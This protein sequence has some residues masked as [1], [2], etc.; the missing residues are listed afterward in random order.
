M[1]DSCLGAPQAHQ[2][3]GN[4]QL[5]AT[6]WAQGLAGKQ[7]GLIRWQ[8]YKASGNRYSCICCYLLASS[9]LDEKHEITMVFMSPL[10]LSRN[11]HAKKLNLRFK[12]KRP[13]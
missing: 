1:P 8:M 12:F 13:L 4:Q 10:A 3:T 6:C 2:P 7:D 11:A 5:P 9:M